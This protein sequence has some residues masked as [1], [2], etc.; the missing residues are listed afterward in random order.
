MN[1]KDF[2]SVITKRI[3]NLNNKVSGL[4]KLL[5]TNSSTFNM[6]ELLIKNSQEIKT[7]NKKE[8][9]PEWKG[10][11]FEKL[12][13][14]KG[15]VYYFEIEKSL[16]KVKL[17]KDFKKYSLKKERSCSKLP[18]VPDYHTDCL[19]VGSVKKN[20]PTRIKQHLGYGKMG[21]KTG[22]DK[23]TGTFSLHLKCWFKNKRLKLFYMELH[24]SELSLEIESGLAE[25]LRPLLGK[26]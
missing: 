21:I 12:K 14:D 9:P 13:R 22:I 2:Q 19:Y 17:V 10:E 6:V 20:F 8:L 11:G 25:Y 26:H 16:N 4:K 23:R 1:K 5:K 15:F 7:L 3:L 18:K 24:D